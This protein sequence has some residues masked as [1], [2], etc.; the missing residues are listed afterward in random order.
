VYT[1]LEKSQ[2]W[3][4]YTLSVWCQK[5][6]QNLPLLIFS[7]FGNFRYFLNFHRLV[8]VLLQAKFCFLIILLRSKEAAC[9]DVKYSSDPGILESFKY[10]VLRAHSKL[11]DEHRRILLPRLIILSVPILLIILILTQ[12]HSGNLQK[13]ER[14]ERWADEAHSKS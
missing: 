8:F 9:N 13:Q 14:H 10:D 3:L 11:G 5:V 1:S 7:Q 6:V 2:A 12:R 4:N